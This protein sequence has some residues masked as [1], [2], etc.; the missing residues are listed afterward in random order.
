MKKRKILYLFPLAALV[1]SGC[2]LQEGLEGAKDFIGS[3]IYSPLK[4]LVQKLMGKEAEEEKEEKK[5]DQKPSGGEQE[6]GEQGGGQGEGGGGESTSNDP[7][8]K[9]GTEHEGTEN[10][11]FTGADA[12]L[13]A[14]QLGES[15]SQ[16]KFPTEESYYI[17]GEVQELEEEFNPTYGNYSFSIEDGFVGWRLKYGSSYQPFNAGDI[18][19][20]DTVTMYAQI[21]NFHG[22][23]E[24]SGGYVTRVE[25]KAIDAEV[26]DLAITGT[27]KSAYLAGEAYSNDGLRAVATYDNG[28]EQDVTLAAEWTYS[29]AVAEVGDTEVQISAAF[30]N[31]SNTI[32]VPVTVQDSSNPAHAGTEQDPYT[33]ADAMIVGNKLEAGAVTEGSFYIKGE[34]VSFEESFN[35]TY[36]NFS[37]KIDGGFIGWRLKFGSEFTPFTSADDLSIGDTVTMYAQIQNYQGKPETKG[38]Y[39]VSIEK[40]TVAPTSI[41]LDK[42]ELELEVGQMAQLTATV[43]PANA[44]NKNVEWTIDQ[45]TGVVSCEDG[46][47]TALEE[48][49]ATV[50]ATALGDP[51]VK[52]ECA[53]TVSAATKE[54]TSVELSGT[55]KTEY[56]A[57]E[58]YSREGLTLSAVYSDQS[59]E[60]VTAVATWEI[61]KETAEAGDTEIT[62]SASYNNLSDS[63]NVAV[64]VTLK[65]GSEALPYTV[66][67]ARAAI[68]NGG[69]ITGV[70]A[71]G[72]VSKIVTAFN[73]QY[74]N[75]SFNISADGLQSGDQLQGYRTAV[76]SADDVAVG[77]KVVLKGNLKKYNDTYE[78]DAGNTIESRV[79]PTAVLS[80]EITG[81]ASQTEYA[82]N[83]TYSHEGLV[84]VANLDNGAKSDVSSVATWAI[85]PTTATLGDT[86]ITVTATYDNVTSEGFAVSVTVTSAPMEQVYKSVSFAAANTSDS[87]SS[88]TAEGTYTDNGFSVKTAN[89]NNNKKGWDFIKCGRKSDASVATITTSAA[90]DKQVTKV[91]ISFTTYTAVSG[92]TAKVLVSSSANMSNPTEY[93]FT[94]AANTTVS[95][96]ITTGVANAYYQ[97]VFDCVAHGSTN[98]YIWVTA[99]SY[100]AVY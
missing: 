8:E 84:A 22:T 63:M 68:D 46:L 80:V 17:K 30:R 91:N 43:L 71:V 92:T 75:V 93:A 87:I 16:E 41:E 61:S 26:T 78:F 38:G 35:P 55:P 7:R 64:T 34:V 79:Q 14:G 74:N 6:G 10:D 47:V 95:V 5:E 86:E 69:D 29:K 89:F 1:L 45:T 90:I 70:Y 52:A 15:G 21:I 42:T 39:I 62:I 27:P 49:T 25:K 24:T 54:L 56:F 48:G 23:A 58:A 96:P 4:A 33:G 57:G 77:D 13:I 31:A 65:P 11:P 3:K 53:V 18:E 60:D 98:G 44:T 88:Y 37:F 100:S 40:P 99:V 72:Y 19:I 2:T 67:E 83:A 50:V 73:G 51:T 85:N 82:P 76:A 28:Q 32:I 36:G 81:T 12:S 20:G 97:V 59:Q 9:Y 66:A 94:P